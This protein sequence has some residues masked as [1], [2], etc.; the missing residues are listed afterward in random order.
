MEN[1]TAPTSHEVLIPAVRVAERIGV[2]RRTLSR[3]LSDP[4]L[5]FP[6]PISINSRLYVREV[7]LNAW[8]AERARLSAGK[9]A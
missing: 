1:P 5:N 3:W 4:N 2:T 7:E 8:L 9:A 6:Q